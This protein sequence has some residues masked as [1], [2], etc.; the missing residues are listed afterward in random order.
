VETARADGERLRGLVAELEKRLGQV[1][2]EAEARVQATVAE[3]APL[4]EELAAARASC[5]R[6]TE[7]VE[8]LRAE[9]DR[10]RDQ[11]VQ[12]A[13][14]THPHREMDAAVLEKALEG[15]SPS[16]GWPWFDP[17]PRE[18][19]LAPPP[20]PVEAPAPVSDGQLVAARQE[21]A[22]LRNENKVL[23]Q[24]L[25]NFGVQLIEM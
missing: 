7:E 14:T 21:V 15:V 1:S 18:E 4:H 2:E 22:R 5:Q 19:R 17:T 10:L 8:G 24:Y 13:P 3:A 11:V 23:R 16:V 12:A 9:R 20:P 25:E 6:I